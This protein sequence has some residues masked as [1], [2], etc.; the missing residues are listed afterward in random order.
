MGIFRRRPPEPLPPN[1]EAGWEVG[2][3]WR[4]DWEPPL[5]L[6]REGHHQAA[7][8]TICGPLRPQGYLMPVRAVLTPEPTNQYDDNALQVVVNGH[9]AGYIRADAA[10]YLAPALRKMR[11]AE[12]AVCGVIRGGNLD[13]ATSFGIHLWLD[14]RLSPGPGIT[15]NGDLDEVG[16]P[17]PPREWEGSADY[18][19]GPKALQC[20]ICRKRGRA[21]ILRGEDGSIIYRC[22]CDAEW[23]N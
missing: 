20:P 17:W 5:N 8:R 16:I 21:Q 4:T 15:I 10:R 13:V 7:Y 11:L 3:E 18:E 19:P 6:V 22:R 2:N 12:F 23:V 1:V 9:M 14:R